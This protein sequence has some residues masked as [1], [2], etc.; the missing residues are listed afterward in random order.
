MV[1]VSAKVGATWGTATTKTV[2]I[3]NL[4][5]KNSRNE[6]YQ[7]ATFTI[8]PVDGSSDWEVFLTTDYRIIIELDGTEEFRGYIGPVRRSYAGKDGANNDIPALEVMCRGLSYALYRYVTDEDTTYEAGTDVGQIVD[9]LYDDFI[10]S[11]ETWTVAYN[12]S[13]KKGIN[14]STGTT[15]DDDIIFDNWTIGDCIAHLADMVGYVFYVDW[16]STNSR[17]RLN[18]T[19][20]YTPATPMVFSDSESDSPDRTILWTHNTFYEGG[21]NIWN[22]VKV[23]GGGHNFAGKVET[24]EDTSSVLSC[25]AGETYGQIIKAPADDFSAIKM[26]MQKHTGVGGYVTMWIADCTYNLCSSSGISIYLSNSFDVGTAGNVYDEDDTTYATWQGIPSSGTRYVKFDAGSSVTAVAARWKGDAPDAL[27]VLKLQKSDN[28]STW[29]DVYT[30]SSSEITNGTLV[31]LS[32]EHTARYWRFHITQDSTGDKTIYELS[33]FVRGCNSGSWHYPYNP[34][35]GTSVGLP[36]TSDNWIFFY[37]EDAVENQYYMVLWQCSS[38]T[39]VYKSTGYADGF[40]LTQNATN[41]E[42]YDS[43]ESDDIFFVGGFGYT[44]P[45]ATSD[46]TTS[47]S[48]DQHPLI[49]RNTKLLTH[50][51]CRAI[52]DW[53]SS[54]YKDGKAWAQIEV[55]GI[56]NLDLSKKVKVYFHALSDSSDDIAPAG[57]LAMEVH[58]Y[59]HE[60]T[61]PTR[62]RTIIE[63]GNP[64]MS[65]AQAIA[66]ANKGKEYHS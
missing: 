64:A 66:N 54:E 61:S 8:I 17:P 53:L 65:V 56:N 32:S 62:W 31:E 42:F 37:D 33:L 15:L 21:H 45:G 5:I 51:I 26:H 50:E 4:K 11:H 38:D 23:L 13:T 30:F 39:D 9:N 28:G 2:A 47:S 29:T 60:V 58:S 43:S 3:Q 25:T 52:A 59:T 20:T 41:T 49:Y 46:Q 27:D 24:T 63:L 35:C 44:T 19:T 18:F 12:S 48:Y 6:Q 36:I 7:T 10:A 34:R 57:G 55:E 22:L 1:S 16:D 40:L 14:T